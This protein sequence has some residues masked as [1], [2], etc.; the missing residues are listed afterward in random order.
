MARSQDDTKTLLARA[1]NGDVEAFAA[2]FEAYRG[3]L[4]RLAY[5]LVGP[6]DC[7]DVVMDTYLKTWRSIPNFRGH[8]S[9]KT[10]LCKALHNCAVDYLRRRSR[11]EAREA[12]P[13]DP[14]E[15]PVIERVPDQAAEPPDEAAARRDLGQVLQAAVARLGEH[16]RT[17]FILREADGLSYGDIAAA[18]GVSIGT[19]MSRLFHARRHLRR[20]LKDVE[21]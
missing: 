13:G 19:V 21:L 20:F 17:A 16:H 9:M 11:K 15:T 18:T 10:W 7:D 5:R 2:V 6:N 12:A 1:R 3:L 14:D 4:H 8:A